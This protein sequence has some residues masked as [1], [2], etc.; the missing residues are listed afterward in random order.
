[1][2]LYP[3]VPR[4]ILWLQRNCNQLRMD[5][6]VRSRKFFDWIWRLAAV[7]SGRNLT[8]PVTATI[9][10]FPRATNTRSPFIVYKSPRSYDECLYIS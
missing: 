10:A 3:A 7:V 5:Q 1:M 4:R 6:Y 2:Y 8:E 9:V